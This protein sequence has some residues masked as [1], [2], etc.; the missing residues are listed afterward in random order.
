MVLRGL[1]LRNRL[2]AAVALA[3]AIVLAGVGG[4]PAIPAYL[5]TSAPRYDPQAWLSGR[6]RFPSGATLTFVSGQKRRPLVSAFYASADAAVFFDGTKA[7]FAGEQ[8]GR[9]SCRGRV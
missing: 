2:V 9:A 4:G 8:I 1:G 6:D 3:G 5:F 7:L